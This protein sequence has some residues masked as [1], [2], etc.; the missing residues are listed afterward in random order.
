MLAHERA[1]L[2]ARHDLVLEAFTVLQRAFPAVVTS[3]QALDE[4]ELLV[5]VL[6]DR[7]ARSRHGA[8]NL[9]AALAALTAG[10][11]AGVP[12]SAIAAS[13]VGL[14][15]RLDLLLDENPHRLQAGMVLVGAIAVLVLPTV[16]VVLPWLT[17]LAD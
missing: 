9:V 17:G 5:E 4:V 1:H 13:E 14:Q 12:E 7:A 2:R 8:R 10:G 16:L 15:A 6:A 11:A 3:R